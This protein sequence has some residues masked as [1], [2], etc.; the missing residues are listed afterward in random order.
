MRGRKKKKA[1]TAENRE[2]VNKTKGVE[3]QFLKHL[4]PRRR[5]IIRANTLDAYTSFGTRGPSPEAP[6]RQ[7][8]RSERR[9]LSP[10]LEFFRSEHVTIAR[11]RA[12]LF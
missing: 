9:P 3:N 10:S 2:K 7:S 8:R 12:L 1:K 4:G 11:R 6:N 5:S